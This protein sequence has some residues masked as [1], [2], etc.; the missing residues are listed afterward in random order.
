MD[1]K[2]PEYAKLNENVSVTFWVERNPIQSQYM[3]SSVGEKTVFDEKFIAKDGKPKEAQTFFQ[4]SLTKTNVKYANRKNAMFSYKFVRKIS[5]DIT[6]LPMTMMPGFKWSWKYEPLYKSQGF[7]RNN[8]GHN[9]E[10]FK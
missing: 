2:P 1:I 4:E 5:E 10:F 8:W 6:N 3:L 7:W 9:L